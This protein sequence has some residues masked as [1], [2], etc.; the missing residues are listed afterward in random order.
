MPDAYLNT[1]GV[2][3]GKAYSLSELYSERMMLSSPDVMRA[4][5]YSSARIMEQSCIE[6]LENNLIIPECTDLLIINN[7]YP[8]EGLIDLDSKN[9]NMPEYL[10]CELLVR[11]FRKD[12]PYIGLGQQGCTGIISAMDIACLR[13][14]SGRNKCVLCVSSDILPKGSRRDVMDTRMLMSDTISF[15]VVTE[16]TTRFKIIA[17]AE[18]SVIGSNFFMLARDGY[19]LLKTLCGEECELEQLENIIFPN[20]W[21]GA[22]SSLMKRYRLNAEFM[23]CTIEEYA[24]G[25]SADVFL[26]LEL[27]DREGRLSPGKRTAILSYGYGGHLRG[28]LIEVQSCEKKLRGELR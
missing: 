13:V 10:A 16:K 22:W 11:K 3:S 25:F 9:H 28:I 6:I 5:G 23:P 2:F 8:A 12:V 20:H 18:K 1:Y 19:E 14:K 21:R 4:E 7:T 27:F 26:N 15:A 17:T 24:H